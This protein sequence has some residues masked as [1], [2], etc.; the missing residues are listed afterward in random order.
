M[1]EG[2]L[3]VKP[4]WRGYILNAARGDGDLTAAM[5]GKQCHHVL[6]EGEKKEVDSA[7]R[8]V[9]DGWTLYTS[10]RSYAPCNPF[11]KVKFDPLAPLPTSFAQW[12]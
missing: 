11:T 2:D 3:F 5:L 8:T 4:S 10:K 9:L 7:I 6:I 1:C 12:D